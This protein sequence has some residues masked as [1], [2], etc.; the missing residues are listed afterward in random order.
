ML[1]E[2]EHSNPNPNLKLFDKPLNCILLDP[3]LNCILLAII[4]I[5]TR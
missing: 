5:L 3:P 2:A 1:C 4:S